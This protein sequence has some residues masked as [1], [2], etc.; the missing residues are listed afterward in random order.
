MQTGY[1]LENVLGG[2]F[3]RALPLIKKGATTIG[4]QML[5]TGS[6]ILEDALSGKNI[7]ASAKKRLKEAGK[8]MGTR[9]VNAAKAGLEKKKQRGA[10]RGRKRRRSTTRRKRARVA[11]RKK[12]IKRKAST[13][14]ATDRKKPRWGPDIFT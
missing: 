8:S 11:T 9:A 4:K 1:G 6:D 10:G 12:P 3:K 2:L 13:S 14:R 5:Q 7:K